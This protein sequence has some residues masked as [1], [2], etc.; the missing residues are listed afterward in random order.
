MHFFKC[1]QSLICIL[2]IPEPVNSEII[3]EN[4]LI[5]H[6][7]LK[8]SITLREFIVIKQ[9]FSKDNPIACLNPPLTL[10]PSPWNPTCCFLSSRS[11]FEDEPDGCKWWNVIPQPRGSRK[12]LQQ[13]RMSHHNNCCNRGEEFTA[14]LSIFPS[15]QRGAGVHL[16]AAHQLSN[17]KQSGPRLHP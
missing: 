2:M 6:E 4:V 7:S 1:V 13:R 10:S 17:V 9:W 12:P 11:P 8:L 14:D 15:K 3:S 16:A 5:I